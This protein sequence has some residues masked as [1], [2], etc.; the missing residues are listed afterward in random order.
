MTLSMM[1]YRRWREMWQGSLSG[2]VKKDEDEDEAK[3]EAELCA[4]VDDRRMISS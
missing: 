3:D 1:E 2:A 4:V